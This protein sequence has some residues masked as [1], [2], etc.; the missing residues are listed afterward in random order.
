M[1]YVF[2]RRPPINLLLQQAL[3]FSRLSSSAGSLLQQA[4]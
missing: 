2:D 3:F 1:V 4:L